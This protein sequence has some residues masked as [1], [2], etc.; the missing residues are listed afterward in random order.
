MFTAA[1]DEPFALP[2][3][4]TTTLA[5]RTQQILAYETGVTRTVDPLGGSYFVESLTDEM[6]AKIV[7]LMQDLEEQ[8]GVVQ[9]I[10]SGHLQLK[11]GDAAA[12]RQSRL[13]SGE[14]VIVGVNKYR[15]ETPLPD[16]QG[17]ALDVDGLRR[18]LDRLAQV[19]RERSHTEV[20]K[21]RMKLEQARLKHDIKLMHLQID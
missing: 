10:E 19:K 21:C 3:E 18:Q 12:R 8:G 9:A 15:S 1:W 4:E 6:E 2:T 7:V 14:E 5:L 16:I 20:T 11:I 13:E 17:Y